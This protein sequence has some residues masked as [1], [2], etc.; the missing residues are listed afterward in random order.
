MDVDPFSIEAMDLFDLQMD[1][2]AKNRLATHSPLLR[3]LL[4]VDQACDTCHLQPFR[5]QAGI[6]CQGMEEI[7]R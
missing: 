7:P 3:A 5:R 2:N 6:Y 4:N 1:Q